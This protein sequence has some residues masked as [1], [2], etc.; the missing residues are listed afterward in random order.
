MFY[1]AKFMPVAYKRFSVR[2]SEVHC[3]EVDRPHLSVHRF[4]L[5]RL[6][7]HLN[8]EPPNPSLYPKKG[9]SSLHRSSGEMTQ[10]TS[11]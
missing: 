3:S 8:P 6:P 9:F 11:S 7:D 5:E 2:G 10:I 1:S 4:P